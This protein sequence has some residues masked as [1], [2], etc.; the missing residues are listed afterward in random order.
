VLR[1]EPV[2][3]E[4]FRAPSVLPVIGALVSL[5]LIVDTARDDLA[6]FARAGLLIAVGVALWAVN[7]LIEGPHGEVEVERLS[8]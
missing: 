2:E 8:G 6:T 1:R 4:H 5:A 3:H 7:R